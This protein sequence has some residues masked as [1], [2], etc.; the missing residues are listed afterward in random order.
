MV[1]AGQDCCQAVVHGGNAAGSLQLQITWLLR[2][3]A[4]VLEDCWFAGVL[5]CCAARQCDCFCT[6][7]VA[8]AAVVVLRCRAAV[9][10]AG[11]LHYST[12]SLL[13]W[14]RQHSRACGA[15]DTSAQAKKKEVNANVNS[16]ILKSLPN[17]G[18]L[19]RIIEFTFAF[20]SLSF[21]CAGV[22]FAPQPL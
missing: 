1:A 7:R 19:F 5:G 20:T 12:A 16:I 4:A 18:K 11:P 21:A 3:T 10:T 22:S 14:G 9:C 13:V 15:N 6:F 17:F 8:G 2:C